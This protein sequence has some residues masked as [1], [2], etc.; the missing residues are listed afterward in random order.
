MHPKSILPAVL[1]GL[2]SVAGFCAAFAAGASGRSLDDFMIGWRGWDDLA[3]ASAYMRD[4]AFPVGPYPMGN[5]HRR[6]SPEFKAFRR[7]LMRDF[8]ERAVTDLWVTADSE[9]LVVRRAYPVTRVD[10]SGR[11]FFLAWFYRLT[12]A[13][14]P[15]LILW[16]PVS[17]VGLSLGWV[18]L[19][20]ALQGR[21]GAA[22]VMSALVTLSAFFREVSALGYAA[23]GFYIAAGFALIAFS[24]ALAARSDSVRVWPRLLAAALVLALA[25]PSRS[26]TALMMPAFVVALI[27][28]AWPSG[29]R[30]RVRAGVIGIALFMVVPR[31]MIRTIDRYSASTL[32]ATDRESWPSPSVAGHDAWPTIW[33]GLG[34]FDR[35]RGHEYR[36]EAAGRIALAGGFRDRIAPAAESYFRQIILGEIGSDPVWFATI[37]ARRVAA[38]FLLDKLWPSASGTGRTYAPSSHPNEGAFDSYMDLAPTADRFGWGRYAFEAPGVSLC[39]GWV[40]LAV[41]WLGPWRRDPGLIRI[42]FPPVMGFMASPVIVTTASAIEMEAMA[43]VHLLVWALFLAGVSGQIR[44]RT[45]RGMSPA[46]EETA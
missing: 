38:T 19:E 27:I 23:Y 7:P 45:P 43:A 2:L 46:S 32:K 37:V 41:L 11:A 35:T 21:Y 15:L 44:F 28:G 29:W 36:D 39:L 20:L 26:A 40:G 34:D 8:R 9:E 17:L 42:L 16:L 5:L 31:M 24:V 6:E 1:I 4:G 33:I 3:I 12:G 13:I 18:A 25:I 14:R 30:A 22:V 10:D